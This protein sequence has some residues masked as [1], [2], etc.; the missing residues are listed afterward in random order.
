MQG[1]GWRGGQSDL[2]YG[3]GWVHPGRGQNMDTNLESPINLVFMSL[4]CGRKPKNHERPEK[5]HREILQT[6]PRK[7]LGMESTT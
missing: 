1:S 5:N 4:D 3:E 7:V 6:P 2:T